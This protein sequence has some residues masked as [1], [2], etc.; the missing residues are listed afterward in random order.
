MAPVNRLER[1]SWLE[2][3]GY[4]YCT[5][6]SWPRSKA[7]SADA[8]LMRKLRKALIDDAGQIALPGEVFLDQ[9]E[10]KAGEDWSR[11]IS[12]ALS[13]SLTMVALCEPA[14][15]G[16]EYCGREF[17]GMELLAAS[18]FDGDVAGILPLMGM[19]GYE[20]PWPGLFQEDEIPPQV[21]R[22]QP[23][24]RSLVRSRRR[25]FEASEKFDDLVREIVAW[26]D[27]VA[28]QAWEKGHPAIDSGGFRLPAESAFADYA[29][30]VRRGGANVA[31]TP[32]RTAVDGASGAG[33][34]LITTFYSYKGGVGRTMAVA[35]VGRLA[36]EETRGAPV[37]LIDWDLE[38]PGLNEYFPEAGEATK[39]LV[40]YFL[41]AD[42]RLRTD[43]AFREGLRTGDG[44]AML[45]SALPMDAYV[46]HT[47]VKDLHLMTAGAAE[48]MATNRYQ[49]G[50]GGLDSLPV[51]GVSRLPEV[52]VWQ[53][54]NRFE[55][56]H[57]RH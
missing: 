4:R 23:L 43:A 5:F 45:G 15:Y 20:R 31:A 17:A 57:L 2:S 27:G 48:A 33:G 36:A 28:T 12:E 6:I 8:I 30:A 25:N 38:A 47:G 24:N 1:L 49:A 34:G 26:I 46:V 3:A 10:V 52:P 22:L 29:Q 35:N 18:R 7:G 19:T 9:A 53:G 16:S 54:P 14:Y 55:N 56:G 11:R 13:Q 21:A 39:G 51:S 44:A 40:D 37:L 32:V 41:D 50:V 42:A